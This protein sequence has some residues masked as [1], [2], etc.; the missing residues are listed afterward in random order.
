MVVR[1]MDLGRVCYGI[2]DLCFEGFSSLS[3]SGDL[4]ADAGIWPNVPFNFYNSTNIAPAG[5]DNSYSLPEQ[6]AL[7]LL[8]A[9]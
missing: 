2:L 6:M 3:V 7:L 9:M 1:L 4:R 5:L 8:Q